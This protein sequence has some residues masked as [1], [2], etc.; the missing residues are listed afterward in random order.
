MK[1]TFQKLKSN[2]YSSNELKENYVNGEVYTRSLE[3]TIITNKIPG[4]VY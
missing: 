1:P 2:Y 3:L 4:T